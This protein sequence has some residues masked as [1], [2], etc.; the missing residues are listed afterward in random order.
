MSSPS[1]RVYIDES[2]EEGFVFR[3]DGSGS[4]RWLILSAVVTRHDNDLQV[5]RLM[6]RARQLLGRAPKQALHFCKLSHA[7]RVVWAREIAATPIRTVSVLIHKPSI[8][9]PERFQSQKHL[10]YR[11]ASRYLLERVSWLCRDHQKPD[12]GNGQA[13][14][15][16]SNRSQMSYDDLRGYLRKLKEETGDF[17]VTIDWSVLNPEAIRAVEHSQLAGLQVADAVASS[18]FAALN[19]NPYGDTED[20]YVRLL[21]PTAYRH[22]GMVLG[23]GLKFWPGD[24]EALKKQNPQLLSFAEGLK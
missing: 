3:P 16:F 5:V 7:Q 13:E 10:L 11:Y 23:Y 19:P 6:E 22:K 12:G 8:R 14:V 18:L 9:E 15:I 1:F 17:G 20:K 24:V 4:S 2:G 21:L